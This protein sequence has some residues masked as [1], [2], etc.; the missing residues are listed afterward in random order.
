[1]LYWI[2]RRDTNWWRQQ[3]AEELLAAACGQLESLLINDYHPLAETSNR[4]A[5][6]TGDVSFSTAVTVRQ[7]VPLLFG[8]QEIIGA[9]YPKYKANGLFGNRSRGS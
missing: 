5:K 9:Q 2:L 4:I 3:S 1:M 6:A 7:I 8:S